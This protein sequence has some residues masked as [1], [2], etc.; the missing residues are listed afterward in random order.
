MS[1]EKRESNKKLK[2]TLGVLATKMH[3][4]NIR[5]FF[6]LSKLTIGPRPTV[7]ALRCKYLPIITG[8]TVSLGNRPILQIIVKIV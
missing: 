1:T 4:F 5:T 8:A 6:P 7:A 3:P 2:S